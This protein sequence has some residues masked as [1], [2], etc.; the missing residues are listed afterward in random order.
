MNDSFDRMINI[1]N[2][3]DFRPDAT[4]EAATQD[5]LSINGIGGFRTKR[6]KR[7]KNRFLRNVKSV[8]GLPEVPMSTLLP[9]SMNT[10]R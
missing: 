3:M 1:K 5:L 4:S 10:S 8:A 6:L 9:M 7:Q 2:K